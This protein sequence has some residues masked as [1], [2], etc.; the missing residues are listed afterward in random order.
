MKQTLLLF[1]TALITAAALAQPV[2]KNQKVYGG[3]NQDYFSTMC[4]ANDSGIVFA[5]SSLSLKSGNKTS[6]NKGD[7]DYWIIK[8]DKNGVKQWERD[9]GGNGY[10]RLADIKPTSDSGFIVVGTSNSNASGSKTADSK[11]DIDY[12]II[13]LDANGNKQWDKTIGGSLADD[14]QYIIQTSDGGYLVAGLSMSDS[15]G[16]KT[17]N[18]INIGET[19][20]NNDVW[21]VKLD[22]SG[23][24][25]WDNT[26]GGT[27]DEGQRIRYQ[28]HEGATRRKLVCKQ[29]AEG[30]FLIATTS[31]S[32][33]SGDKTADRHD[34]YCDYWV[35]KTDVNGT[36]L[37]DK[38]IGGD[39]EEY[40][41]AMDIAP[42]GS[43]LIGGY[44]WSNASF[45]KTEG[46]KV[47]DFWI[48]KLSSA[49][50]IQWD[51]TIGGGAEDILQDIQ[52]TSDGG[53]ILAGNST[54]GKSGDKTTPSQG[55]NDYWIVKINSTGDKEWNKSIGGTHDDVCYGVVA[56][57]PNEYYLGGQSYSP[58]S[59]DKKVDSIGGWDYWT[60]RLIYNPV[61]AALTTAPIASSKLSTEPDAKSFLLYPNPATT[62]LHIQ[63]M[64][65]ATFVLSDQSGRRLLTKTINGNSDLNVA[66]IPAGTYYLSNTTTGTTQKVVITK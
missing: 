17:E 24:K 60:M 23:N 26:I 38:T 65:K 29:T 52:Y 7:L 25:Q 9:F 11:G 51:K 15:T 32:N 66:A 50:S 59:G 22:A 54:S 1:A 47:S 42:D 10:D 28:N 41:S 33:I 36:V 40:L 5:G 6:S 8:Q 62:V 49:G 43:F 48:V 61:N 34:G 3:I 56:Y 55:G 4:M 16:D 58:I 21:I 64:G 57:K 39:G 2:I 18:N 37:W 19:W 20:R 35:V 13:K 44:S 12:W 14:A 27:A 46:K 53:F 45:E 63:N 31:Q 30:G